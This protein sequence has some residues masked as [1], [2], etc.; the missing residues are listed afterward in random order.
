MSRDD[1]WSRR[2]RHD[3]QWPRFAAEIPPELAAEIDALRPTVIAPNSLTRAQVVR[4]GLR[5]WL[6]HHA[7]EP[8][9][10]EPAIE[11][12]AVEIV[13]PKLLTAEAD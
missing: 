10:P 1:A 8:P 3:E 4:A 12:T 5:L 7:P 13:E 9:P 2:K 6:N 11:S